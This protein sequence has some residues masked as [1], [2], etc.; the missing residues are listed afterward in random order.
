[1]S[2]HAI[3]CTCKDGWMCPICVTF[4]EEVLAASQER[5][6]EYERTEPLKIK[7]RNEL[8]A[9]NAEL[10]REIAEYESECETCQHYDEKM[11]ECMSVVGCRYEKKERYRCADRD[12]GCGHCERSE[13]HPHPDEQPGDECDKMGKRVTCERVTQ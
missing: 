10:E 6:A 2:E 8:R 4:M 11:A 13:P 12:D 5:V 1:M 7:E 3:G 9:R